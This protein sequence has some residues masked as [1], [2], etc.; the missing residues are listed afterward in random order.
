MEVGVS[1]KR[2]CILL[3][4]LGLLISLL[5]VGIVQAATPYDLTTAGSTVTINGAI[6]EAF[7]PTDPTGSGI[8]DPFVR[9]SSNLQ[10]IKGYNTDFRP[11]QFEEN[12]SPT[13]TRSRLL[14]AVP[15]VKVNGVW[16]R[17]F[18]LDINQNKTSD[19]Y[20]ESLDTVQLFESP[21]NDLCGY[22]FDGSGVH[23]GCN[24]HKTATMVWD[25]DG[26][27]DTF[28][29]LDYRNNEGSGKRDMRLMVPNSVFN[30][31]AA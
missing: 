22:P 16:Y 27:G 18:Q 23:A 29:V 8:F 14:S 11:L 26:T 5:A 15:Q 12:S 6:F 9:I 21:Y 13:F 17:E 24:N 30:Q 2:F 10:V 7:N 1:G 25:M 19:D 4:V 31:S 20:L 28:V 3:F